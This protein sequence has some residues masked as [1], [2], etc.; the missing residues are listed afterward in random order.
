MKQFNRLFWVH[1]KISAANPYNWVGGNDICVNLLQRIR[2]SFD[3]GMRK[4]SE[5][6]LG[7]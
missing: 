3:N 4:S 6:K 5:V 1:I 7:E 2:K